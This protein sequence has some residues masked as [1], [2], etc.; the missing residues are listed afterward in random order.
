MRSLP[1]RDRRAPRATNERSARVVWIAH[2]AVLS[3]EIARRAALVERDA[4]RHGAPAVRERDI[5]GRI[6]HWREARARAEE[7]RG[8]QQDG[9]VQVRHELPNVE[10]RACR[11]LDRE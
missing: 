3:A 10:L 8:R 9:V 6:A 2:V 1:L 4:R 7:Q 11:V 5:E